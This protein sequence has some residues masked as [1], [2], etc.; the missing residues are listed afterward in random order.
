MA[1]R[2]R[3]AHYGRRALAF[4]GALALGAAGIAAAALVPWPEAR[5]EPPSSVV[6][7]EASGQSRVCP[8][9][10]LAIAENA[11]DAS[12]LTSFSRP[13]RRAASAADMFATDPETEQPAETPLAAPQN[14]DAGR[15]GTPV[16]L[17]AEAG[18]APGGL[19]GAQSQRAETETQTGFAAAACGESRDDVWLVAGATDVGRTSLVL[20]AN[21]SEV[22]ATVDLEVYGSQGRIEAPAATGLVIPAGTQRVVSLAGLAPDERMPVVHVVSDGGGVLA[23]IQ[24]SVIRGLA[25]GGVELAGATAAP[26]TDQLIPGFVVGTDGGVDPLDDHADHAEGDDHP[27]V[28]VFAPD[29]DGDAE[30]SV[31]IIPEGG[32][33]GSTIDMTLEAGQAGDLA[34]GVLDAGAYTIRVQADRPVVAAA[35]ASIV[36]GDER[37]FA[38]YAAAAPLLDE[39]LA[40]VP[41]GPSPVLHL[42]NGGGEEAEAVVVAGGR[43]RTVTIPAG[44]AATVSVDA[45][46][47]LLLGEVRGLYASISYR[48]DGQ[49][50]SFAIQ[51]PS[52]EDS[53]LRVYTR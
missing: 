38:W 11:E 14:A 5:T 2:R 46:A 39:Q 29:G 10:L 31:S 13:E 47:A 27:I 48:G 40:V 34:L 43:E 24:H 30:V 9:P 20:L 18:T 21:A 17:D 37:D 8:G 49:L 19:A 4:A 26:S 52:P 35:R 41:P 23:S 44:Q 50:S 12:S 33:R 6:Q 28:R 7:P 36:S 15:D 32:G 1:D 3:L 51:P 42:A 25:P 16:R 45:G 53:P 22:D